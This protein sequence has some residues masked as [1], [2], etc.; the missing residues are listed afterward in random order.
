MAK[1]PK[2]CGPHH[3][4]G[5]WYAWR[6][7]KQIYFPG[8]FGSPE[9]VMAYR[10]FL[11]EI[12][13]EKPL[14]D[15]SEYT[16]A[17]LFEAWFKEH[18]ATCPKKKYSHYLQ[19]CKSV[20]S[21]G[22]ASTLAADFGPRKLR[23]VRDGMVES[24]WAMSTINQ[25]VGRI[26]KVFKWGVSS[27]LV[28]PDVM[29]SIYSLSGIVAGDTSAPS[30]RA[31]KPIDW[32]RVEEIRPLLSDTVYQM[33]QV[34]W[35]TGMRPDNL[36]SL[37]MSQV[38]KKDEVWLYA[39]VQHKTKYKGK[40]LSITLGPKTQ[41]ILASCAGSRPASEYIFRPE[42]SV[43]WHAANNPKYCPWNDRELSA[44]FTP[45]TIRQAAIRAQAH[46]ANMNVGST[47]PTKADFIQ[48]GWVP[49]TVYQLRH[50]AATELRQTYSIEHVRAYLGH[51]TL[52]A[53]EIYSE[54]DLT[55][56]KKIALDRG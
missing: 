27:E 11:S 7:G 34:L 56:A 12:A 40:G 39:P 9:S 49:W 19:C 13:G 17:E 24:G 3:P 52:S 18:E 26:K 6:K 51:A 30:P 21:R 16:V 45:N 55:S 5:K 36:C 14:P 44:K 10:R 41:K 22:Y 29:H 48:A 32:S 33:L 38:I 54:I 50:A 23:D 53:T 28:P 37:T 46:K 20:I 2:Y 47:L 1:P 15:K 8:D 4:S 35:Y 25:R 42:D 31:I 43:A